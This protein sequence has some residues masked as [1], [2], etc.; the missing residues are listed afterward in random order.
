MIFSLINIENQ[1]SIRIIKQIG[2]IIIKNMID[3]MMK[4]QIEINIKLDNNKDSRG[5]QYVNRNNLFCSWNYI[6]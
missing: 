3:N 2:I 6:W 1:L 5:D 4:E